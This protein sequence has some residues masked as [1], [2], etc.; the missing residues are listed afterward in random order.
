MIVF[1]RSAGPNFVRRLS[2]RKVQTSIWFSLIA[3]VLLFITSAASAQVSPA[4]GPDS[5]RSDT[6]QLGTGFLTG[7]VKTTAEKIVSDTNAELARQGKSIRVQLL[8]FKFWSPS[9]FQTQYTNR[10]NEWY[11]KI[12]TMI[13]INVDIPVVADRQI[14]IPVDLN[15][16]CDKWF[17]G[18]GMIKVTAQSGPMSVEGGSILED[19]IHIRD[20]IDSQVKSHLP[21]LGA[22]TQTIPNSQCVTLG[23]SPSSGTSDAFSFVAW[24]P[25]GR[26]LPTGGILKTGSV[27]VTFTRIKR[28]PARGN[29][30]TVLYNPVENLRLD[31]WTNFNERQSSVITMRENDDVAISIPTIVINAPLPSSLVLIV[32]VDQEPLGSIEDSAFVAALKTANYSAGTHTIQISKHYTIPPSGMNRKPILAQTPGYEISYVVKY[33]APPM[34]VQ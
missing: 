6:K 7:V 24:D 23:A 34:A 27:E 2:R 31:V 32:N 4:L 3:L 11:V 15:I 5:Y 16:T 9:R 10:P 30:G 8:P 1:N 19:V 20:Y 28:L 33:A 25:P 14:Y 26:R 22:V 18:S 12:P 13:G 17:T 21:T 29:G